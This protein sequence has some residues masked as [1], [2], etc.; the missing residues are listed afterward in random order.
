MVYV[1]SSLAQLVLLVYHFSDVRTQARAVIGKYD[2]ALYARKKL[3]A[4][5]LFKACHHL[6]YT[7][8]RVAERF[9][10]L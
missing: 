4:E 5:L 8:L 9:R 6:A 7:G 1:K 10:C 2:A 3:H